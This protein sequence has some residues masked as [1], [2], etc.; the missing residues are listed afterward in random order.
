MM[1]QKYKYLYLN[2]CFNIMH[3]LPQ[4]QQFMQCSA[5]VTINPLLSPVT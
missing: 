2:L 5:A 4:K 1:V 3:I